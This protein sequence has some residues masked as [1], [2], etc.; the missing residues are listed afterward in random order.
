MGCALQIHDLCL[1]IWVIG[2]LGQGLKGNR[3]DNIKYT[4][5]PLYMYYVTR[6]ITRWQTGIPVLKI[7][8]AQM[9]GGIDIH[10]DRQTYKYL[11]FQSSL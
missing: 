3:M 2:L 10:I 4:P 6:S 5:F 7:E 9:K 1:I 8:W 11:Y